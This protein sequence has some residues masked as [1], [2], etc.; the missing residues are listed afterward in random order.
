MKRL[1]LGIVFEFWQERKGWVAG[2]VFA[3]ILVTAVSLAFPYV[4]RLIVDGIK[5]GV[6]RAELIRYVLYLAGFG[7]LRCLGDVLLPFVRGR[8]NER[9]QWVVRS[10]VFDRILRMGHTFTN[11]FPTGDV[12]ERLDHDLGELSWFACSGLFRFLAAGMMVLFALILM[13]R[14]NPLLTL[15]SVL[16]SGLAVIGWLRMGPKVYRWF[17]KWREKIAEVNNQ[18]QAAFSGIR[19][20]KA[21]VMEERLARRFQATLDDR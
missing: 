9:F 17:M 1:G 13:A 21:Y 10:R 8:I 11:R 4:L 20:V 19:L 3:T 16:P 15:V 2:L 7:L 5:A 14:M 12:M 6:N 18:L